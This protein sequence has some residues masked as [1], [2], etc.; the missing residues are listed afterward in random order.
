MR[1]PKTEQLLTDVRRAVTAAREGGVTVH[2]CIWDATCAA[3]DGDSRQ[4]PSKEARQ[5][6][7]GA[8][9][10]IEPPAAKANPQPQLKAPLA[11]RLLWALANRITEGRHG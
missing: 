11:A 9:R 2:A 7:D 5:I 10:A 6:A 8:C 4:W 3:V 1:D